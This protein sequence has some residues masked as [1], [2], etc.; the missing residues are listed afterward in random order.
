MQTVIYWTAGMGTALFVLGLI[1]A[2]GSHHRRRSRMVYAKFE[3]SHRTS[4]T[5]VKKQSSDDAMK[6]AASGRKELFAQISGN[7]R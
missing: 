4:E 3:S 5:E 2:I 6:E 7:T 1:S